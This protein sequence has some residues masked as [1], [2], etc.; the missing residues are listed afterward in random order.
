VTMGPLST[1][2]AALSMTVSS[3]SSPGDPLST[4]DLP[5]PGR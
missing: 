4:Q 1:R 2:V 3:L 5:L